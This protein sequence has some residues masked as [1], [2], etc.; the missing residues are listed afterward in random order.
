MDFKEEARSLQ[1][2]IQERRRWLHQHPEKSFAEKETTAYLVG[3]LEKMGIPVQTFPDYYGVIGTIEGKH[4]GAVV[5]LRSDIDAL[6]LREE[7]DLS[8]KSQNPGQM[9]ACGHDCHMS[10]LLGAARLLQSHKEEL[11]GTVKLLFQS[12][13]E[14]GHG[15]NYYV[16]KGVLDGIDGAMAIHM[17]NEIPEGTF[18]I[19]KGPRMSSCTDFVLTIRGVSAHGSTPHLG[20]DAIVAASAVILNI[21]TLVSRQNNPLS[22]LV[23]TLGSV[24]AGRQFNIIADSVVLEGT[25]RTFDR[26]TFNT[27]PGRLEKMAATTA[28]AL[29]CTADF[30]ITTREPAVINDKE[31]LL[32]LAQGAAKK[33]FSRDVLASMK[34]KM[35]SED[36]S[37]I[38][39]R[40]PAVQCFLGYH[41]EAKGTVYP[42]HSKDFC[43]DDSILYKGAGLYAQFAA[44]FLAEN[45]PG[46]KRA[47]E[48]QR[49]EPEQA[50]NGLRDPKAGG[51]HD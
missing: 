8:Y 37:V 14:S 3:E 9:H 43:I 36:F 18:S 45:V 38:M 5:L 15:S 47:P 33:L 16:E 7:N 1:S 29:G 42:L 17:M 24:R 46:E 44:D 10:M 31:E 30:V 39:E 25:I 28:E 20:K 21:Q 50:E 4:S 13:E 2:Y 48:Q 49:R 35:G 22:P 34:E 11:A 32:R 19:E 41:N 12:G 51:Q 26:D 6:N 40:I 27:L 23:V